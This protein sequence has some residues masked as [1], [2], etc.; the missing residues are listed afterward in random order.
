MESSITP[1]GMETMPTGPTKTQRAAVATPAI[2]L[3][4]FMTDAATTSGRQDVAARL[5]DY[6]TCFAEFLR[7][8]GNGQKILQAS[9]MRAAFRSCESLARS[10]HS[11]A[12]AALP[13]R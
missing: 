6:D 12:L 9:L 1:V 8:S 7:P 4:D 13:N 10:K 11:R 5:R 3:E 2:A